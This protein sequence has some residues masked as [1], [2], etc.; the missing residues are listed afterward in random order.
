MKCVNWSSFDFHI[1]SQD[2][3]TPLIV[4]AVM[5]RFKAVSLMTKNTNSAL[6]FLQEAGWMTSAVFAHLEDYVNTDIK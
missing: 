3:E 1:V 6:R 5:V 2:E 4:T